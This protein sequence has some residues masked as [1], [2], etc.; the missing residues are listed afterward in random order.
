MISL[1]HL[2]HWV[3]DRAGHSTLSSAVVPVEVAHIRKRRRIV[4]RLPQFNGSFSCPRRRR[5][6]CLKPGAVH[7][8]A[9]PNR[10][11]QIL[12]PRGTEDVFCG[13]FS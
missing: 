3:T 6:V 9:R 5:L 12:H 13:P 10:Q 7:Q 8:R 11:N 2:S 1:G 4:S